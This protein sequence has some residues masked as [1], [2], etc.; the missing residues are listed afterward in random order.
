MKKGK[1]KP[2]V[3]RIAKK[4][5][6]R[7]VKRK[8]RKT[9]GGR[10]LLCFVFI[11]EFD[12]EF[13]GSTIIAESRNQAIALVSQKVTWV[14]TEWIIHEVEIPAEGIIIENSIPE[15]KTY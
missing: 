3:K 10:P 1:K 8:R 15:K 4:R 2:K 5:Q 11:S 7:T 9:T 13:D 6:P 14:E 12:N